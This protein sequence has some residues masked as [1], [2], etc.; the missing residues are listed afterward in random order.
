MNA[1]DYDRYKR[2]LL[3]KQQELSAGVQ[4]TAKRLIVAPSLFCRA[5]VGA[6]STIMP[7]ASLG[8]RKHPVC[9]GATGG[10]VFLDGSFSLRVWHF[11]FV[12]EERLLTATAFTLE[13]VGGHR[14]RGL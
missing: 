4:G 6:T 12:D 11:T 8:R 10:A 2:L 7:G 5:P 9:Q 1:K 14:R 13:H 3:L